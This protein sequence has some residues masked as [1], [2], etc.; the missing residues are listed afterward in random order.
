MTEPVADF[1]VAIGSNG[2][3]TNQASVRKALDQDPALRA[4]IEKVDRLLDKEKEV[5]DP[6]G[7]APDQGMKPAGQLVATEEVAVGRI[8]W[9]TCKIA[10]CRPSQRLEFIRSTFAT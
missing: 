3:V 8:G 6:S 2:R 9:K 1:I 5:L 7:D 4:D 10:L